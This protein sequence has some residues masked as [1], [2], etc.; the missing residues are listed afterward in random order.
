MYGPESGAGSLEDTPFV[1]EG[2]EKELCKA[3]AER[4]V[5]YLKM[6]VFPLHRL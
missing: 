5:R 6:N 4:V 3:Q 1:L 2:V